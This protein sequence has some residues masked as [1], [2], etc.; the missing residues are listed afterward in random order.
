MRVLIVCSGNSISGIS[1][2]IKEQGD[3]LVAIGVK[4]DYFLIK[5][6]GIYGYLKNGKRL[7]DLI[8]S[9]HPD[10]IHAH[11][12][13]SGVLAN[14]Q[15]KI[16]VVTTYHG[17]DINDLVPYYFSRVS[18]WLSNFNIFVSSKLAMKA[19]VKTKFLIQS[20]GV[21]L[22]NFTFID[23]EEAR[24]TLGLRPDGKYVLFSSSFSNKIKNYPLAK[25]ALNELIKI[26]IN[27]ELL[28]LKGYNRKE[29]NLLMNAVD[30]VLVTSFKESGPLVIKEAMAVNT[31][32]VS[33]DVGDVKEVV[34][35]IDGY[36]ISTYSSQ[37]VAGKIK[38]ALEFAKTKGRTKGRERL[39]EWGLD[40][41]TVAK[42]IIGVYEKVLNIR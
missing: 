18:I 1:P 7:I 13:L 19:G 30:C 33:V 38:M 4:I 16:P 37:D 17:S 28:E 42:R 25:A 11:Y 40:S 27:V 2:F 39:V 24:K 20:C 41:E 14:L 23:R 9:F 3:S 5:G 26:G 31:C 29:V 8:N 10:L 15:R 21:N 32:A 12:G 35:N 36:Y 34:G 22:K 6:H